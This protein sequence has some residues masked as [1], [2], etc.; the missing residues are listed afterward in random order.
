MSPRMETPHPARCAR[1]LLPLEVG[2]IR[3]RQI[4]YANSGKPE[5]VG[6]KGRKQL[7]RRAT[8]TAGLLVVSGEHAHDIGFLHDQ[9]IFAVELD[10]GAGPLAEQHAIA[11]L[12][13][14]REELAGLVAPPGPTATTRPSWGFSLA[15]SGMMMPPLVFSSASIRLTTTRSCR[16]RNWV[17]AMTV[18]FGGL[19]FRSGS[20][21][22]CHPKVDGNTGL[23]DPTKGR[24]TR[25]LSNRAFGVLIVRPGIWLD[26]DPVKQRGG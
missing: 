19:V 13:V 25:T 14:D 23:F 26:A 6:E 2:Y 1:H 8:T 7:R 4:Q 15:L 9:Q 5:L 10:L 24:T 16:G 18:P 22:V 20:G 11:G 12:D 3:L 17:L 21:P